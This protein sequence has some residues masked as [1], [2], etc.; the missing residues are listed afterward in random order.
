MKKRRSVVRVILPDGIN[1]LTPE[2]ESLVECLRYAGLVSIHPV[3][4]DRLCFDL[5][6]PPGL[7]S[8]M[9]ADM[10]AARMRSFAYNA[11]VAPHVAD[12]GPRPKGEE[13]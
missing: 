3:G 6:C 9:W 5:N 12:G 13:S 10:N 8:E 1:H 7:D 2:V 11:V 4:E